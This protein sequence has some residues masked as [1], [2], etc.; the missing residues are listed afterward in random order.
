MKIKLAVFDM[1]GT[2][3]Q[4]QNYVGKAFL[5]AL[6]SFGYASV[7]PREVQAVMGYEKP[8]AI[9]TLLQQHEPDTSKIKDS[10]VHE[11]H[12][13]FVSNMIDF[14]RQTP[15]IQPT[16]HAEETLQKLQE[17]GVKIGLNTGFSRDI[18]EV[19]IERLRWKEKGLFHYLVASDEVSQ[20]RPYPHMI[21]KMMSMAGVT[22]PTEVV[23]IGDTKV[24]IEEGKNVGCRYII[25]VTTGAYTREA[26]AAYQPTH[27]VDDLSELIDILQEDLPVLTKPSSL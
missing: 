5:H 6:Q 20:G 14:Y 10:L 4:D 8:Q 22:E 9:R 21:F 1:A 13:V 7:Q 17:R 18:A 15:N 3:V 12:Q 25:A 16:P 11:I 27:I 2:T 23:K 26:L 24:D 19:I